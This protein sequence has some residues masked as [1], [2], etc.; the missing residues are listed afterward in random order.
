MI[1]TN[2]DIL[3]GTEGMDIEQ[4]REVL[5]V[6]MEKEVR[7]ELLGEEDLADRKEEDYPWI[8]F[9]LN[10]QEYAINSMYVLSLELLGETTNIVDAPHFCP[11]ITSSRGEM[12][13]LLDLRALFGRGDF[14]SEIADPDS[15]VMMMVIETGNKKRG[16]LVDEV[17]SVEYITNF[18]GGGEGSSRAIKSQYVREVATREKLDTP[19]LIINQEALKLLN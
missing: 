13:E 3:E 9:S 2:D 6:Q 1:Q 7:K 11:G 19:V 5:R 12:I 10:K 14:L 16:M 17:A 15:S 8:V 4:I 18:V